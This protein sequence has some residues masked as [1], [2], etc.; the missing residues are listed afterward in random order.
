MQSLAQ[1][2]A[3]QSLEVVFS[4]LLSLFFLGQELPNLWQ[5][6]DVLTL[7]FGIL[8]INIRIK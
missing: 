2:E 1:V 7:L 5:W 8:M 4:I 6:L 3:T